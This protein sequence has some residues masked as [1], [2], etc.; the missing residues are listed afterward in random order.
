VEVSDEVHTA[1]RSAPWQELLVC[2]R[3]GTDDDDDDDDNNKNINNMIITN[4]EILPTQRC[5]LNLNKRKINT[6]LFS[7]KISVYQLM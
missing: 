7:L 4:L 2:S 6:T 1:H 3:S 5:I